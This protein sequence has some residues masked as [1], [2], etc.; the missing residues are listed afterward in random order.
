MSANRY[1]D[2]VGNNMVIKT[3]SSV[4][5]N[6]VWYFDQ[7]SYTIKSRKTNKSFDIINAGKTDKMQVYNTNSGWF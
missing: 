4:R 7:R 6:Q 1:L 3:P 5:K 2:L